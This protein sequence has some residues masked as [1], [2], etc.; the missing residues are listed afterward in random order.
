LK[1]YRRIAT[2]Y[3]KTAINFLGL[4]CLAS[5]LVWLA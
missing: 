2:R 3:E 1:Q 4:V 5:S